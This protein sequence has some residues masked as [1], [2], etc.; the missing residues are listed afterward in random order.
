MIYIPIIIVITTILIDLYLTS[1]DRFE[2]F[3]SNNI[4]EPWDKIETNSSTIG[5]K[6]YI[7]INSLGLNNKYIKKLN[8]WKEL[9]LKNKSNEDYNPISIEDDSIVFNT[10]RES[11]ALVLCNLVINNLNNNI[12]MDEIITDKLIKKTINKAKKY[13]LICIKLRDLINE[14]MIQLNKNDNEIE[15]INT[16]TALINNDN[17]DNIDNIIM[18]DDNIQYGGTGGSIIDTSI[19]INSTELYDIPI[20]TNFNI[21]CIE[22]LWLSFIIKHYYGWTIKF[23][24]KYM[25]YTLN[26]ENS[27]SLKNS[28]YVTLYKEK[29]SLI[30][31][32]INNFNYIKKID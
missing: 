9:T 27:N 16:N 7:N 20:N 21:Y 11:D 14:G 2:Y 19:F 12:T 24:G 28:L 1:R 8:I 4:T 18:L 3:Q 15:Y 13:D 25:E 29:Q 32:L 6:Y 17:I 5:S 26:Y 30:N 10:V 23:S 31:Y 22:D